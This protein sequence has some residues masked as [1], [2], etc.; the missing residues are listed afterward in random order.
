MAFT[1]CHFCDEVV[2]GKNAFKYAGLASLPILTKTDLPE[3]HNP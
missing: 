3:K 2:K 1:H